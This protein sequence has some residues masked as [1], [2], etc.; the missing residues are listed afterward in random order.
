MAAKPGVDAAGA[1]GNGRGWVRLAAAVA[2]LLLAGLYGLAF[3]AAA[4]RVVLPCDFSA[5]RLQVLPAVTGWLARWDWLW[6][7]VPAAALG[8]GARARRRPLLFELTLAAAWLLA[9][10]WVLFIHL[11]WLLPA[12]PLC[13]PITGSGPPT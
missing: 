2:A 1:G 9:L 3:D 7:A 11:A 12:V 5:D 8:L 4:A 13:G 10:A 6:L